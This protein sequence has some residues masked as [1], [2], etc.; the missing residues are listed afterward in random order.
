ME[1][2]Q[3]TTRNG[4]RLVQQDRVRE[5]APFPPATN[6]A[7][8]TTAAPTRARYQILAILFLVT[9]LNYADRAT[10]SIVGTDLSADLR[11]DAVTLGYLLSAFSVTYVV[12]QVPGG[13]LLDA[14]GS[15]RVYRWS[16]LGWSAFTLA[17]AVTPLVVAAGGA[18][19]LAAGTLFGLRLGLG[20]AEAPS[21]PANS[22]IVAAWFP[23]AERGMA[24]AV[25][26]SAQYFSTVL[27]YPIMGAITHQLGWPWVF[28]LMG[29]LGL[30][31]G[32]AWN[33]IVHDP[34][35]HPGANAAEI[36]YIEAG[37]GLVDLDRRGTAARLVPSRPQGALIL[38]LLRNRMLAGIFLGQYGITAIT[39]FFLTWFPIYLV[40]ARGLTILEV[41][42]VAT[43]PALCG[44]A[45]GLLGGWISDRLLARRLS[46]TAARKIPIVGGLLLSTAM[47]GCNYVASPSA[48]VALMSLAFFGKGVGALGWAVMSDV[49]PREATG[50]AGGLFNTIGNLAGVLTPIA[51]GYILRETGSF[52]GALIFVG[53]HALLAIV[54]FLAIVGEIRRV[55]LPAVAAV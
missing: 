17:Q 32:L 52:A 36:A 49:A 2:V 44:F 3:Q 55:E 8:E 13:W 54:S 33:R 23:T 53:A 7:T 22:R 27:F 25:F 46:L 12:L 15:R 31:F 11:L 10:L 35:D 9:T 18:V 37:G 45:G 51:I 48:V 47:V 34:R 39:W 50:L 26:N 14:L 5:P 16:L 20:A 29:G 24:S 42:F 1:A 6:R 43:L 4:A 21:F 19:R 28:V 40:K 30:V 41:G 38:T